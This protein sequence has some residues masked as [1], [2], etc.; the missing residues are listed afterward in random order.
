MVAPI[1][2]NYRIRLLHAAVHDPFSILNLRPMENGIGFHQRI[3][4]AKPF[5]EGPF[6][7]AELIDSEHAFITL[8]G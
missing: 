1:Y 4:K 7:Q 2:E 3:M 5:K 8:Q 6:K